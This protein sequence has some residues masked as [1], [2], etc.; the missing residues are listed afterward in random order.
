MTD[1]VELRPTTLRKFS[2]G[3]EVPSK[4]E[5]R[6]VVKQSGK[7][8]AML[9]DMLG[10]DGRTIRRWVGGERDMPYAAWRLLIYSVGLIDKDDII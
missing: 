7:T 10:V 8:G 3:Y 5:V 2:D 9:G 1:D 6:A 4:Y